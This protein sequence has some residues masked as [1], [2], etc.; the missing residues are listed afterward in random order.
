MKRATALRGGLA[1]ATL[2]GA[3]TSVLLHYS[4][5]WIEPPRVTLEPPDAG[6]GEEVRFAS[7]DGVALY[8]WLLRAAAA[9]PVIVVCHGYQRGIEETLSIGCELRDGGF[10]VLLF[11]FRGCGRSGGRYTTLGY[12]EPRDLHGALAWVREQFGDER[13]IGALGISLGGS[14]V[15]S[16]M[17]DEP[18]IGAAVIDSAFA[19]LRAA[20]DYRFRHLS[21][22]SRQVHL[23][24]MHV[25]ERLIGATVDAVR[26]IEGARRISDRPL[27]LVHGTADEVVPYAEALALDAAIPGPHELWT[28]SN[29]YHAMAR[30][31]GSAGYAQ[32]VAAFFRQHLDRPRVVAA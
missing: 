13:P 23:L 10:N 5:K 19:T 26:P 18:S 6:C 11:E 30:F 16:A 24:S 27:L 7:A 9:D 15:L 14:V 12:Y 20:V 17:A 28:V 29:A 3:F 8:G 1:A 25:A 22:L 4:R 21:S 32:R 2:G 31:I